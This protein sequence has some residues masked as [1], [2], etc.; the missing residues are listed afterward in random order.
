MG[1]FL[2]LVVLLQA[3]CL[4]MILTPLL[5]RAAPWF[6]FVDHPDASRRVHVTPTPLL[7]GAAIYFSF[8]LTVLL[9]L[10]ALHF[11]APYGDPD[12]SVIQRLIAQSAIHIPGIAKRKFELIGLLLGG[13]I[14]FAVG[15]YDDRYAIRPKIKL[16]GQVLAALVF[17][18]FFYYTGD[19]VFF[20]IENPFIIACLMVLWIVGITNSINFMDNMD[21]LCSGVAAISLFFFILVTHYLGGQTFMVLSMLALLG[22][23]L[24]FWWYNFGPAS[25]KGKIFMGDA[26]SMFIGFML[27]C[28]IVFSTFYNSQSKTIFSLAM[29]IIILAVPIFDTATVVAIRI[30]R[31]LPIYQGDLNH[32]SHRL[33]ELGMSHRTAVLFIYLVSLCTGIG[34]LLLHQVEASG[35]LIILIQVGIILGIILLL[36]RVGR[37]SNSSGEDNPS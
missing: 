2:Y 7:G 17:F 12:G 9:N 36:E 22:G 13:S 31:G 30:K 29:P 18:F 10:L 37:K 16:T 19:R 34:A 35:G 28:L 15:L 14:V 5:K 1:I 4:S 24:G 20:F 32:F 33:V 26:G 21:G 23:I 6:G 11:A 27:A 25:G 3:F 8:I